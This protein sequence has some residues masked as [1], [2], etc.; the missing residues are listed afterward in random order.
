[1]VADD[2]RLA[3]APS[4]RSHAVMAR[5]ER[6]AVAQHRARVM[7]AAVLEAGGQLEAHLAVEQVAN[8][9]ERAVARSS[10]MVGWSSG[11]GDKALERTSGGQAG[12]SCRATRD[13]TTTR[14]I[15]HVN[16]PK[17][18]DDGPLTTVACADGH[19]SSAVPKA[20]RWRAM[21]MFR[22]PRQDPEELDR[23][24]QQL[25]YIREQFD[26]AEGSR[27]SMADDLSKLSEKVS[28]AEVATAPRG[29]VDALSAK[30]DE[31]RTKLDVWTK[32]QNALSEQLSALDQRCHVGVDRVGQP[33]QRAQQRHREARRLAGG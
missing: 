23:L 28:A 21:G 30:V 33:A 3:V 9:S 8:R 13:E 12:G 16:A 32:S 5:R 31:M 18:I 27:G 4:E 22:R 11:V 2:H 29:D 24:K 17:A 15:G 26:S 6:D 25:S 7:E 14:E 19:A 20:I 10:A 1:M